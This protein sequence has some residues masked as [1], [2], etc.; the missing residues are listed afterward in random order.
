MPRRQIENTIPVLPVRDLGSSI[1]LLRGADG[2]TVLATSRER[3]N[4]EEEWLFPLVG[5]AVPPGEQWT[6]AD[7]GVIRPIADAMLLFSQAAQRVQP[8]FDPELD[9]RAIAHI[10]RLV[11]GACHWGSNWP[12]D[13]CAT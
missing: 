13:G 11:D 7:A 4:L 6:Q 9:E 2:I 1:T 12:P 8:A 3:L 5:L 10:C